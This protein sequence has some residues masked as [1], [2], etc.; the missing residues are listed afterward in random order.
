MSENS[1]ITPDRPSEPI[2]SSGKWAHL[3]EFELK[4]LKD[5][6]KAYDEIVQ[7]IDDISRIASRYQ[8]S[9]E[10]VQRAKNYA[11][12]SGVSSNK[13]SPDLRMAAAWNRMAL[14]EGTNID[15]VLLRHE[16]F[17]SDLVVNRGMNQREAHDIAQ[18]R[19]PWSE[20]IV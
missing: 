6:I 1:E 20:L 10:E 5:A 17:E 4:Y 11:F 18:E 7:E 12:G 15:E 9:A 3:N 13:F 19:Y 2:P 16:V 8:L 14:G